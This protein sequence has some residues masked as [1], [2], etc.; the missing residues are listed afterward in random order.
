MVDFEYLYRGLC[1][2]AN[3]P[4]ANSMAG[5]LGAAV[6]AG[7]FLGEDH[8][9]LEVG[10][11]RAIERDLNR[12]TGGEESIWFDPKKAGITSA[13]LFKPFAEEKP[14]K[15]LIDTIARALEANIGKTRQSGHNVIFASIAIRALSGHEQ[16]ASPTL[17]TGIEKLIS[18]FNDQH[19]GRGYYGKER[20]WLIGN[21]APLADASETP[22][23]ESLDAMA[24]TV[25]DQLIATAAEHRRGFGGLFHLINHAAALTELD[26]HGYSELAE[27]GLAAHRQHLR[28]FQAL[29][30][31]EEELGKL[32]TTSLD[33]F[34]A[35][36]WK[37]MESKQWGAWLTH[38]IKTL[39]GFHTLLRFVENEEK[40]AKALKQFHYLM[41]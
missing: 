8:P 10:V 31:L 24:E 11:F 36:Y 23:H 34:E 14:Q 20:G 9:D 2:M 7:Y 39:Y 21:K 38:R 27:K 35:E 40:R 15:A 25:I 33:P 12:I 41:A 18:S 29:P 1:G 28:L 17:V 32:E 3:A 22:E 6:I 37:K 16:H 13:E 4:R 19:P 30:D 26:R 5:H